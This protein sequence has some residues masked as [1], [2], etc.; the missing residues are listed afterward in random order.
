MTGVQPATS[1]L[2]KKPSTKIY[3]CPEGCGKVFN[4][5]Y[6][7]Q[8]HMRTHTGEMPFHCKMCDKKFKWR[9]S[10]TN[11]MRYHREDAAGL[12]KSAS[13]Q[14]PDQDKT[15]SA[16]SCDSAYRR[17]SSCVS[18]AS[19]RD[20]LHSDVSHGSVLSPRQKP[21]VSP[22]HD[23][24]VFR[25]LSNCSVIEGERCSDAEMSESEGENFYVSVKFCAA[26]ASGAEAKSAQN[27]MGLM[28]CPRSGCEI[29]FK[30]QSDLETHIK[31]HSLRH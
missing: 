21:L 6:N 22:R 7:I 11:H 16:N 20:D 10:W 14:L 12:H 23:G 2:A 29:F 28:P 27:A 26:E 8:A 1:R 9:S 30:R 3:H 24:S 5:R 19:S 25:L 4:W 18:A 13:M 31:E 15:L 17:F